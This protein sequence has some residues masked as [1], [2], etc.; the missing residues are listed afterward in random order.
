MQICLLP[1]KVSNAPSQAV[2]QYLYLGETR[3][4]KE[5]VSSFLD[6]ARELQVEGLGAGIELQEETEKQLNSAAG[7]MEHSPHKED[8]KR[9]KTHTALVDDSSRE[10]SVENGRED[11]G[12]A[13]IEE[14][15]IGKGMIGKELQESRNVLACDICG[16]KSSCL[17]ASNSRTSIKRHKKNAHPDLGTLDNTVYEGSVAEYTHNK[18]VK[19]RSPQTKNIKH[20]DTSGHSLA[21]SILEEPDYRHNP[22]NNILT[23]ASVTRELFSDKSVH[24][25]MMEDFEDNEEEA[26]KVRDDDSDKDE[27]NH[28]SDDEDEAQRKP[29]GQ[30][31]GEANT[32]ASKDADEDS[33]DD[34][35]NPEREDE[36]KGKIETGIEAGGE[37]LTEEESL[38]ADIT[39]L[40]KALKE[41]TAKVNDK[42]EPAQIITEAGKEACNL[43]GFKSNCLK[44][45][46]RRFA[47][48][49]HKIKSHPGNLE[50]Q[51]PPIKDD[52]KNQEDSDINMEMMKRLRY[53]EDM[54]PDV[55]PGYENKT[56]SKD[57]PTMS[58]ALSKQKK[59]DCPSCSFSTAYSR[60]LKRHSTTHSNAVLEPQFNQPFKREI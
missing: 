57:L 60:S 3:I 48:K 45:N 44:A 50:I 38:L 4:Q 47:I 52:F 6:T 18:S 54:V 55:E 56:H 35:D 5:Q 9:V 27:Y 24:D 29:S 28:E 25:N 51:K 23:K 22:S 14:E 16:F 46:N 11:M 34:E 42:I 17:T 10:L 15:S 7:S 43:C 19:H 59:F 33:E 53:I 39:Q 1:C 58:S 49:R 30:T 13:I 36:E 20:L 32:E 26:N 8:V 21:S 40:N 2:L 37:A 12:P 31:K 41:I